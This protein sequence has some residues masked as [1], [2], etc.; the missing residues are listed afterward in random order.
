ME[1]YIPQ[2]GDSV[3]AKR[4]TKSRIYGNLLIGP[5]CNVSKNCCTM[6]NNQG[7]DIE[8]SWTLFFNDWEFTKLN[9][10]SFED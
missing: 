3:S 7:T 5:I 2:I 4:V 8:T 1:R 10:T 9:Y 6:I